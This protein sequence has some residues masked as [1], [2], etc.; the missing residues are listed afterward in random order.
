[1][2][3]VTEVNFNVGLVF[4]CRVAKFGW[5]SVTEQN[6]IT[7]ILLNK[8]MSC[9]VLQPHLFNSYTLTDIMVS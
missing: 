1:M 8:Q 3:T 4:V 7:I 2:K 6:I 9:Y 5:N